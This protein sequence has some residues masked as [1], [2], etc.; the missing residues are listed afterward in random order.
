MVSLQVLCTGA[1]ESS[2]RLPCW[3][4]PCHAPVSRTHCTGQ[5][6]GFAVITMAFTTSGSL[7]SRRGMGER[8]MFT[9]AVSRLV[10]SASLAGTRPDLGFASL[11]PGYLLVLLFVLLLGEHGWFTDESD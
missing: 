9:S 8:L 4:C 3:H 6:S 1:L 7:T 2:L 10:P 11:R 5:F